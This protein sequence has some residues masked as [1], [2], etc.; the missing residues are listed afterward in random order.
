MNVADRI[1]RNARIKPDG[2]ALIEP[3]SG[4]VVTWRQLDD[5][6]TAL[7]SALV[8][9]VGLA[10]G[11]RVAI[12]AKNCIEYFEIYLACAKSGCVA[13]GMNWHFALPAMVEALRDSAPELVIVQDE[14]AERA[15]EL[16]RELEISE[17][18]QFGPGSDG[19]Y[20][21]LIA[22]GTNSQL[23]VRG[24]DDD[25]L[26]IMY[27]G[28]T[29]GDSKG[30][31]HSHSTVATAM[32]NNTI[33]ERI[34]PTDR[35]MLIGQA[36]H[37][38]AVLA[39][40]YL[41]HGCPVVVV[42]FEPK[43]ALEAIDECGVTCFLGFPTMLTYMLQ[44]GTSGRFNLQGLR[45][46]Q[47][48]GG[49]FAEA[50]IFAL[51]DTFPCT[52][53]QCYGTTES[54]GVTFLS[55]EDHVRARRERPSLLRSCGVPAFLTDVRLSTDVDGG[56]EFDGRVVG[57][58]QVRSGSNMLGYWGDWKRNGASARREWLP[59]GDLAY[60]DE[61]GY[62]YIVGRSKDVII[63][64]G[65]NIY[66]PQVE[67]A[68]YKHPAVLEAAVIGVPD[69][70]WGEAVRAVVVLRPGQT[71]TE[72]DIQEWVRAELGSYQKP[73]TVQFVDALPKTPTGKIMK[74]ALQ[75]AE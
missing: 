31:L 71:A 33:A 49:M 2:A 74:R 11:D 59:T 45:N 4:R 72:H 66:A 27:T 39:L 17:W 51:L 5:R 28:G 65:E 54:I 52:L 10:A 40:N 46:I 73:K 15:T 21:E 61:D 37:S 9:R 7:A 47:Y 70:V 26:M 32:A 42:N 29:T 34:V 60:A 67:N 16:Q 55:Q 63:S 8:G 13:H 25:P 64:G 36:F 38:A 18:R 14:F 44:E 53:I 6:S 22:S 30:A 3:A 75:Q 41:R 20:E 50:T 35:Y 1:C 12:V 57:E 19:S 24:G 56:A 48:G 58:I 69:D 68:I 62:L 23:Q 43:S